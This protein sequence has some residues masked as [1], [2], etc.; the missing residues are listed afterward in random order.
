[1]TAVLRKLQ[2]EGR[3]PAL[4][5]ER[6]QGTSIPVL[7]N[8][9]ASRKRLALLFDTTEDDLVQAYVRRQDQHIAPTQVPSG[10]VKEVVAVGDAADVTKLPQ[11][12]HCGEDGGPYISSGVVVAK[13]PAT[14]IYNAGIY[15]IQIVG[16]RKL[17]I[18]PG[19][20]SHLWHLHRAQEARDRPLDI[21]IVIGHYPT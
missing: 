16:P 6:I 7:A 12:V 20:Y 15:R 5:F 4:L 1:M 10:P 21:A 14:G 8:A 17:R 11:I 19:A 13:D 3:F 18:Y 9:L 2:D